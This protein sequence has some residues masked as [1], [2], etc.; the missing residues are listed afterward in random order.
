MA[1]TIVK[2]KAKDVEKIESSQIVQPEVVDEYASLK[3]KLDKKKAKLAP[4]E[5]E[6]GKLEKGILGAVDEILD[7]SVSIDLQGNESELKVG[8]KGQRTELAD[9][10]KA[11]DILGTELFLKLAKI[12]ITDLK[13]YMTPEQLAE[14]T[15]STYAIKR[16][17]KVEQL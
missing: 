7:P 14:V 3:T 15:Q 12:S 10:E 8:P 5:K 16:R 6:V 13:A 4:L 9:A 11:M 17:V 1:V 2:P